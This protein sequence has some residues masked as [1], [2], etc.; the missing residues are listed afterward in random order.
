MG[1]SDTRE[2]RT[3]L[4][5]SI[6]SIP[7]WRGYTYTADKEMDRHVSNRKGIR[8]TR[9]QAMR[10]KV[11]SGGFYI[12]HALV[13]CTDAM[14]TRKEIA[15]SFL[16]V[17]AYILSGKR[18]SAGIFYDVWCAPLCTGRTR[19]FTPQCA[20]SVEPDINARAKELLHHSFSSL[21]DRIQTK[22]NFPVHHVSG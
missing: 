1:H 14:L 9:L 12:S 15:V 4:L 10:D 17:P 8:N 16:G 22:R 2:E 18:L 3:D 6:P 13:R 5:F 11:M 20:S 19:I 21:A 7:T